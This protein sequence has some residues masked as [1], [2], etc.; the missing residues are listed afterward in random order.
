MMALQPGS[1]GEAPQVEDLGFFFR[2]LGE[3]CFSSAADQSFNGPAA[4]VAVAAT[5]GAVFFSD[6]QGA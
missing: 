4:C 3:V 5:C 6:A 2:R 1:V